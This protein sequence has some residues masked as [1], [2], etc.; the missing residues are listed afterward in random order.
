ME[1]T[2]RARRLARRKTLRVAGI[3]AVIVT[4]FGVARR[5]T[6]AAMLSNL[7]DTEIIGIIAGLAIGT[8]IALWWLRDPRSVR[9]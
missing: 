8:L 1:D 9:P 2:Q 4:V 3:L 5:V 6:G 7:T